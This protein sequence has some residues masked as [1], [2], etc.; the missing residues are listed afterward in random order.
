MHIVHIFMNILDV[1]AFIHYVRCKFIHAYI[2]CT[3]ISAHAR[4]K[5]IQKYTGC[6]H[7]YI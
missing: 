5:Y 7:L 1:L 4:C 6:I 3:Q 2:R